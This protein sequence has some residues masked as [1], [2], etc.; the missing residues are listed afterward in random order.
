MFK[1]LK[2]SVSFCP[3]IALPFFTKFTSFIISAFNFNFKKIKFYPILN[4]YLGFFVENVYLGITCFKIILMYW[5]R[6]RWKHIYKLFWDE[7]IILLEIRKFP[8]WA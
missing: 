6:A 5:L 7:K 2:S 1:H 4:Q 8:F 3:F